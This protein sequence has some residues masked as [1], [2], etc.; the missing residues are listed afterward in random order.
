MALEVFLLEKAA[1]RGFFL[2]F[3]TALIVLK[4]A[5]VGE[6]FLTAMVITT[7]FRLKK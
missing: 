6:G 7:F 1:L 4:G 5:K 3:V 2:F